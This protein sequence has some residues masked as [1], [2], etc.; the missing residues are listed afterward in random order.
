MSSPPDATSMPF[1]LSVVTVAPGRGHPTKRL[2]PDAEGRPIAD[3]EHGL[4]IARGS[5]QHVQVLGLHGLAALIQRIRTRKTPALVHGVP[6]GSAIKERWKLVPDAAYTGTPG[7]IARTLDCFAYPE[8]TKLLMLDVDHEPEAPV[9]VDTVEALL[10][11]LQAF[12]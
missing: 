4:W 10:E 7:T 5:V 8:P 1:A 2:I 3:P 9:Q 11:H 6:K 12:W